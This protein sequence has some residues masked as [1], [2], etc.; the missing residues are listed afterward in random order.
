[1]FPEYQNLSYT[2]NVNFA[3]VMEKFILDL[4]VSS[5]NKKH[6]GLRRGNLFSGFLLKLY[7]LML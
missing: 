4:V 6:V 2:V 1:M 7:G 5:I 3:R